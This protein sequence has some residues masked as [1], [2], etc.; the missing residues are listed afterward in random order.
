MFIFIWKP[1]YNSNGGAL[2]VGDYDNAVDE[3]GK[4]A[5]SNC[6]HV[7]Y[8]LDENLEPVTIWSGEQFAS[9]AIQEIHKGLNT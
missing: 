5:V 3:M 9:L 1:T 6:P 7:V 4:T 2:Y 8:K